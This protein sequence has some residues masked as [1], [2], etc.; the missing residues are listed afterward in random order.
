MIVAPQSVL[1]QPG[2]SCPCQAVITPF[3]ILTFRKRRGFHVFFEAK[4]SNTSR[5]PAGSCCRP[6]MWFAFTQA[7][8]VC[9][10]VS[11]FSPFSYLFLASFKSYHRLGFAYYG[12]PLLKDLIVLTQYYM[13]KKEKYRHL[14]EEFFN[15]L[16]S[17]P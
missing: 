6:P 5:V 17:R 8:P 1:L 11:S 13:S 7:S 12:I 14:Y 4:G 10:T 2:A 3:D 15:V 16:I 9:P